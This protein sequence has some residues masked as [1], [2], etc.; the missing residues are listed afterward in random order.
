MGFVTGCTVGAIYSL[1]I[2]ECLRVS[3]LENFQLQKRGSVMYTSRSVNRN[4]IGESGYL[5]Q[6]RN[7]LSY[8]TIFPLRNL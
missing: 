3:S 7:V 4:I 6:R 5:I 8:N 1:V 2:F